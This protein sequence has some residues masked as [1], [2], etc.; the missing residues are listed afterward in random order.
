MAYASAAWVVWR[1]W[2]GKSRATLFAIFNLSGWTGFWL[3]SGSAARLWWS[4]AC[5]SWGQRAQV[6]IAHTICLLCVVPPVQFNPPLLLGT[7]LIRSSRV[8]PRSLGGEH[9]HIVPLRSWEGESRKGSLRNSST[10]GPGSRV[11]ELVPASKSEFLFCSPWCI[12]N[13]KGKSTALRFPALTVI[14]LRFSE[15]VV[16][17]FVLALGLILQAAEYYFERA[18]ATYLSWLAKD[19]LY[20]DVLFVFDRDL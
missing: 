19:T 1:L 11:L 4:T 16:V 13:W 8:W 5:Q 12:L 10:S 3:W 17:V 6:A 7:F 15:V 18:S 2:F 9:G 14:Q 20:H